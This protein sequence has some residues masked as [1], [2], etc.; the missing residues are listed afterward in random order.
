[1]TEMP[2][3]KQKAALRTRIRGVLRGLSPTEKS[4]AGHQLCERLTTQ[5]TWLEAGSVLLFMPL[6]DEPHIRP[7][8]PRALAEGKA[9]ALPRFVAATGCYEAALIRDPARDLEVGK[10]GIAEPAASCEATPLKRLD[11]VLAPGLAFDWRG[12]RLG[13]GKGF[14]D[15]LL[16][17]VPGKTCGVAFDQQMVDAVP[18]EPHDIRLNC[19][20]TPS[21]WLEL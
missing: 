19:I 7:L 18:I 14:Y 1:M 16:A 15:R 12:H 4:G 6:P 5:T 17:A 13:R 2:I 3:D 9:V 8:L 20:I 21:R 10:F 11:L